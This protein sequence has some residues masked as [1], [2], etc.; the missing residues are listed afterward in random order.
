[1]PDSNGYHSPSPR[2]IRWLVT[3]SSS[4]SRVP[5]V[6]S[7]ALAIPHAG[8]LDGPLRR[9]ACE[10]FPRTVGDVRPERD[11]SRT[12]ARY[13]CLVVTSQFQGGVIGHP[14]RSKVAF[15][16]GAY[17]F[18]RIAGRPGV[19]RDPEVTTPKSCGG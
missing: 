5:T 2:R 11:L 10:H 17:A 6:T 4:A 3:G 18:C 14:Y 12:T 7:S 19:E 15:R 9:V 16:E 8:Q 13:A 1:M